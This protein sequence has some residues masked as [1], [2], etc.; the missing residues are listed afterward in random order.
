MTQEKFDVL[1]PNVVVVVG[2]LVVEVLVAVAVVV[3][4]VELLTVI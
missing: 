2:A 4:V 3:G 1:L